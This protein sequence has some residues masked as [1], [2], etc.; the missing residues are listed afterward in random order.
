MTTTIAWINQSTAQLADIDAQRIVEAL[1][2]QAGDLKAAWADVDVTNVFVAADGGVPAG[3][4]KAYFLPNADV[5]GA[6]GYHDVDPQGDPY[7][8]VFT[9]TVL[10]AGGSALSGAVSIAVCASHEMCE[11]A[12][13]PS[14]TTNVTDG[15]GR[16]W[17]KEV[18]D[19]VESSSYDVTIGD[20]TAVAVSDFVFPSFFDTA[21][22]AP[23][24]KLGVETA[25]FTIAKGGYAII[26]GGQ[27]FGEEY[28][29]WRKALKTSPASRTFRRT[30]GIATGEAT[31]ETREGVEAPAEL[32]SDAPA[33]TS[34][35][36]ETHPGQTGF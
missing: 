34:A 4:V 19:P 36:N 33:E 28:P 32:T 22:T 31:G 16:T 18:G 6:L 1:N 17:A 12:V 14:C 23:F 30:H 11:E 27:V 13:D 2:V 35:E 10:D 7:I 20:G 9:Q 29:E 8:R 24:D 21:G 25:P 26:D 3:A 15:Q 5:A